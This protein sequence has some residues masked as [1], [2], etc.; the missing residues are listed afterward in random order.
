M[1]EMWTIVRR[2]GHKSI[3]GSEENISVRGQNF[4]YNFRSK[5]LYSISRSLADIDYI[6]TMNHCH[7][8]PEYNSLYMSTTLPINI[9]FPYN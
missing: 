7:Q 9:P 6:I 3:Q 8:Q 2:D 1:I 4:Q 5:V